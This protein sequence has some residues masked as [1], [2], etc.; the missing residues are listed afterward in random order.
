M[1]AIVDI[2]TTGGSPKYERITEIAIFIHDGIKVVDEFISLINPER[3]IPAH[4]SSLTGITNEMVADA[5]KFF[6]IAKRIVEVTENTV[7]VAHN[8]AFD[9][10]FIKNE[11]KLL[12]Y[13]FKRECLCTVK[14]SRKLIP[15]F[16]SYSL[17]V[18]CD[19]LG[20]KIKN[21]HRASGDA[22]A[23][24]RLFELLLGLKEGPCLP[25]YEFT[26][27]FLKDLNK[28]FNQQILKDLPEETGL[29]YFYDDKGN[30]LYIGKSK[31][32]RSRVISHL[33]NNQ[34]KKGIEMKQKI[35]DISYDITGSEL[36]ALLKESAEIK[37]HK[38][39]YNKAQ[40]R[41]MFQYG[42]FS[43]TDK[44]GYIN[45]V[46][47]KN[48]VDGDRPVFSFGSKKEATDYLF[49]QIE[50]YQLCQK[51]CGLYKSEGCCFHYELMEC[52]GAC[53]GKEDCKSYNHRAEKF[54]S[55]ISFKNRNTILIDTGRSCEE[56]SIIKIEN[57]KY[58]GF[59]YVDKDQSIL[60]PQ[61]FDDY[62]IKYQ[63]NHEVQS[64]L[65]S[66]IEKKKILKKIDY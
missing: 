8:V 32:I 57:G 54:L 60:N 38:P 50:K 11:F 26:P 66:F 27:D 5:P 64:M 37:K 42:L 17:G 31:N 16:R 49:R 18:L 43:Y 12:G 56:Y 59:G 45:F 24:V 34:T 58:I 7:F 3:Y 46:I 48:S 19:E 41:S 36:I 33:S 30:I 22:L 4:I 63:D 23:T 29:Y 20:I 28:S 14:L 35:I 55:S 13:T 15:G 51:L 52:K 47:E 53:I 40:R 62:I 61:E 1:Y 44:N 2:E 39:L 6:E 9:Y 21:R 25:F 10:G 65:R